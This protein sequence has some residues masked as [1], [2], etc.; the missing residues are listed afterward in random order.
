MALPLSYNLRNLL[1]RW[2]VT[3]LAIFGIGLVVMVFVILLAM[4]SGF[5]L[6]LAATGSDANGIVVQRGS[7]SE[8]TSWINSEN[9]N[10]IV[11]D[12]RVAHDAGGQPLASREIVVVA[13]LPKRDSRDPTNV[14]IRGVTPV[15]FKVRSGIRITQGRNFTT[16][17]SEVIVGE[18]IQRRI[19]GL[20]LGAT[21]KLQRRDW[22]VVGVFSAEGGAFESEIWGDFDVMGPAFLRRGGQNSLTLRLAD[23]A[24]LPA[25][26]TELQA[27]RQ[28]QVRM[29]SERQYYEDQSAPVSRPLMALAWFVSIVMGIGAVFGAMNTMYAIVVARTK[30]IGTL[31]A[32]GFSRR[33][34]LVSFMIESLI[35]ALVGGAVG[36]LLAFPM[37]GFATGTGNTAGFAE[38][39]FAFRLTPQDLAFGLAFALVMGFLGGLL[40]AVR[41]S[42]LPI[43]AALREA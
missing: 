10:L 31:R 34:I 18:R 6:S 27:N 14:T 22:Q 9:G 39:A 26:D 4:A 25:F 13:N 28:M 36:C 38:I 24:T 5:R 12:P 42:R 1:V 15:A 33:S 23:P 7:G 35:L 16:G 29:V 21:V 20:D 43:T 37:N 19:A 17:L 40:P 11:V 41:A 32:L 3:L 8:L 30:E 2:K